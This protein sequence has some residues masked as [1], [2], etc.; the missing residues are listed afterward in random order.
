MAPA[1]PLVGACSQ[2]L[3]LPFYRSSSK[4]SSP[5]A[6]LLE[7][8][9]SLLFLL[10]SWRWAGLQQIPKHSVLPLCF[11]KRCSS[12][13]VV[14]SS[15]KLSEGCPKGWGKGGSSSERTEQPKRPGAE[16]GASREGWVFCASLP[17][18][19]AALLYLS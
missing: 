11:T 12:A 13:S 8:T 10:L 18:R 1:S 6:C 2:V 9:D 5:A 14:T 17:E 15:R 4:F 7:S 16:R 19:S 3:D